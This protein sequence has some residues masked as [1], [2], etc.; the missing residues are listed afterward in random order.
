[1]RVTVRTFAMLRELS[2]DRLEVELPHGTH[3]EDAWVA[4]AE[5]YPALL[6]HRPFVRAAHNGAYASW[7]AGLA[8]GDVVAFLPPVSG[9]ADTALTDHPIDVHALEASVATSGRGALV[10]FV[11]RARDTSDDGREV[12]QLDY[13][14]Y[15]ELAAGVLAEIATEA[16]SRWPVAVAVVH[17]TGGV[18]IGEAA[19]AI[20]T[21]AAHRAEAYEAN[22]FVIEAIKQRLPI[23]KRETFAD[24]S[25]WKRPGA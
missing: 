24:G 1:M 7:G 12:Q 9:G 20:V 23:W 13:E 17:R 14:V 16:E 8:E 11:G 22:R 19:V 21:G 6:P 15:P 25:E 4:M 2:A 5:R 18:P 3:L 10:T